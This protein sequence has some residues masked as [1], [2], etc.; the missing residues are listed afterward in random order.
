MK[1]KLLIF[2]ICYLIIIAF[3]AIFVPM[4]PNVDA[5]KFDPNYI[6]EPEPPSIR[7]ILG[8]DDF[9]RDV[10]LRCIY[11]A[12]ISLTVG[13]VAVSIMLIVGMTIGLIAGYKGGFFDEIV[14][15]LVDVFMS[16]P[17]IFLI[18]TIQVLLK[19]SIYNVMIVIG[20]TS[21]VGVAR[22]VRAEVMSIKER[23]YILAA[24]ARGFSNFRLLLKHILPHTLN[25]VIVAMILSIGIAILIEST[26]SFLGM[27]VQPPQASW[28]NMLENSLSFMRDAPWMVFAPGFFITLTV[29]AFNFLG[30]GLRGIINPKT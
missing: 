4:L 23:P 8:T 18:L 25:P 7:H 1:K 30:D 9:G 27:G 26:L 12:R 3:L 14:M 19:P 15:R 6:S 28:G 5:N 21:W 17:T 10:L 11:G 16:I 20:L 29:L 24:R 13:L 22:I 2:S